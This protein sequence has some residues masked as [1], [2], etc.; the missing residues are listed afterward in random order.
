MA[1][2]RLERLTGEIGFDLVIA[3]DNPDVSMM[4]DPDLCR[5]QNMT[6]RVKRNPDTIDFEWLAVRDRL[7]SRTFV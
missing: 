2:D 1:T 7:Y 6:G 5:A 3:R 4:F